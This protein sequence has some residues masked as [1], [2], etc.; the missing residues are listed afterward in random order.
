MRKLL[1][2]L[3]ASLAFAGAAQAQVSCTGVSGINS[4]PQIGVNCN[5]EPTVAT[6]GAM[7]FGIVPAASAT[8]VACITGSATKVVRVQQVRVGGTAGTL[9]TL[10]VLL[11]KH[12][13][14]NTGGTA[15][16]T[17]ALPVPVT[18]DTG[19][20]TT[21]AAT[22]TVTAY[23]VNPTVDASALQI[24]A[25]LASFNV[26]TA[27]V[28]GSQAWFDY[29]ER[30][31]SSAPVLRGIAQQVCVNLGTISVSSGLLAIS[32]VWTEAAQ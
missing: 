9:V 10:P 15:A 31:F 4:V 3:A 30:S 17:T 14:A 32:F 18:F 5:Q 20:A 23:T 21:A 11:N 22:A 8:D 25:Q 13:I 12:T 6:F 28:N 16:T 2:A 19:V 26:T 24:D 29:K 27:L 7:G 1:L